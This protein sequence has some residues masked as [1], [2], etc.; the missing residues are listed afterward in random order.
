MFRCKFDCKF[1]R[2]QRQKNSLSR[3]RERLQIHAHI[4]SPNYVRAKAIFGVNSNENIADTD[5]KIT[6]SI[7]IHVIKGD[8]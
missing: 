4:F 8:Y 1:S 2:Y 7:T 6:E 5:V 3:N